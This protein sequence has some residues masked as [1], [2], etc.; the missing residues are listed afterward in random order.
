MYYNYRIYIYDDFLTAEECKTIIEMGKQKGFAQS[1]VNGIKDG[2]RI[3]VV[4]KDRTSKNCFIHTKD[5]KLLQKIDRKTQKIS[6]KPA[7]NFEPLQVVKYDPDQ[8]YK[9]HFD[10]TYKDLKGGLRYCTLLIYLNEDF[11]EGT[12]NFPMIHKKVQPKTGRAVLFYNV[13][14]WPNHKIIHPLSKH[15]G[16]PPKNGTKYV[17]NKW[18]RCG[19]YI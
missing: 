6:K 10:A 4:S 5:N 8:Y 2:K 18:V 14:S 17:C 7:C 15:A 19:K 3:D 9:Q 11:E 1:K 12:T 13:C 16:I